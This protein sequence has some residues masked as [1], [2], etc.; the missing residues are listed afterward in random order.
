MFTGTDPRQCGSCHAPGTETDRT[1]KAIYQQITNANDSLQDAQ[2]TVERARSLGMIVAEEDDLL[3]NARTKLITA[4]A[5]Q[6]TIDTATVEKVSNESIQLSTQAKA[7]ANTAIEQNA[8]R[9]QAMV[10]AIGV[11]V[12]VIGSLVLLRRELAAGR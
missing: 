10:I 11:I 7:N 8:F 3:V 5:A 2:T 1:V 12:V 9:R 6:H 4:R